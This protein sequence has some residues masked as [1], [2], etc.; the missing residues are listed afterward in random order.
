MLNTFDEIKG[1]W[2]LVQLHSTLVN[3]VLL[4]EG[5]EDYRWLMS[6]MVR[7]NQHLEVAVRALLGVL[8]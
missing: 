1:R 3:G 6:Q 5:F 8:K 7:K 2:V 4:A